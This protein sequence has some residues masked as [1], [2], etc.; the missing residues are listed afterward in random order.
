[1]KLI[2]HEIDDC[3]RYTIVIPTAAYTAGVSTIIARLTSSDPADECAVASSVKSY[4]FWSSEK[5]VSTYMGINTFVT[6]RPDDKEE[7]NGTC[8]AVAGACASEPCRP[9]ALN[10]VLTC[11]TYPRLYI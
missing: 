11:P 9:A 2:T 4:N 3:L 6:L 7:K 8:V 5:G 10:F 1:M